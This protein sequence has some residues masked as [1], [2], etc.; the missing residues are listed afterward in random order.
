MA[1]LT[2]V[3]DT[4]IGAGVAALAPLTVEFPFTVAG[5][6]A[7]PVAVVA[8][9]VIWAFVIRGAGTAARDAF[10]GADFADL[11]LFAVSIVIAGEGWIA[12]S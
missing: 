2:A 6:E 5:G 8:I 4:D 7:A 1:I 10:T 9:Q 3:I 11:I 12:K